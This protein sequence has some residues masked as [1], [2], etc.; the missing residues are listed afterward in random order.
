MVRLER[1]D[2]RMVIWMYNVRSE[3]V[4]PAYELRTRIK[5]KIMRELLLTRLVN[6]LDDLYIHLFI[7]PDLSITPM[8]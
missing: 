6:A 8:K 4:I 3:D 2:A 5:S 1:I 7:T